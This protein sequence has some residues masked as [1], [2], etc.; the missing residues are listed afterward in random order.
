MCQPS[1][2][3]GTLPTGVFFGCIIED[4]SLVPKELKKVCSS[5]KSE[6]LSEGGTLSLTIISVQVSK[7][8]VC[9]LDLLPSAALSS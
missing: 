7:I 4:H 1:S 3:V 8:T 9:D 2:A 5:L 6:A